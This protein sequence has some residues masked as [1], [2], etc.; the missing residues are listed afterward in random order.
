MSAS[1]ELDYISVVYFSG[2]V[3]VFEVPPL[4]ILRQIIGWQGSNSQAST[5]E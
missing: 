5:T 4:P 2:Q 1:E 3:K